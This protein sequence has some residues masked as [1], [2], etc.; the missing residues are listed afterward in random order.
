MTE[1]RFTFARNY[2][3]Q[4]NEVWAIAYSKHHADVISTALNELVEENEELKEER[5]YFERKKCEYWNRYNNKHLNNI[6]LKKEKE[7]LKKRLYECE[8]DYIMETY[9]DNPIRRDAKLED[10]KKG[11][12]E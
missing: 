10:L 5:D 6:Q 7:E 2:I 9:A 3:L 12:Q 1:K 11:L 8:E 4:N